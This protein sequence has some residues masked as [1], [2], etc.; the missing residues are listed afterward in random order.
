MGMLDDRGRLLGRVNLL[1]A[2][3]VL[4][5]VVLVPLAYGSWVLFR[6]PP[7]IIDGVSPTLLA[8]FRDGQYVHM[9]GRYFRPYL[10][11]NV[12]PRAVTFLFESPDSAQ[13][14]LPGFDPGV[15][16]VVLY[17]F[18]KEVARYSKAVTVEDVPHDPPPAPQVDKPVVPPK[19][20]PVQVVVRFITRPEIMETVK[21]APPNRVVPVAPGKAP[22]P[23]LESYEVTDVLKGT[24]PSELREGTISVVR[25]VVR[26]MAVLTPAGWQYN[27]SAL[28]AG[29]SFVLDTDTYVLNGMILSIDVLGPAGKAPDG[30]S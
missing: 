19:L 8:A 3:V 25:G 30:R 26:V 13:V 27:G 23:V 6:Q 1:D 7:P 28:K 10:R 21:R 4:F 9:R 18:G 14:Q 5:V 11:A 12:G 2:A 16:D 24:S 17:E 22:P 20:V 15:Y 29:A